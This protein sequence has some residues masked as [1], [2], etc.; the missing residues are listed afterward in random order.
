MLKYLPLIAW[1]PGSDALYIGFYDPLLVALSIG[2]A[3]FASYAGLLVSHQVTS[4]SLTRTRNIWVVV[5]GLCLGIGIWAMHFIGMLAFSLPCASSYD[6]TGTFLSTIPAVLAS[7]LAISIIGKKDLGFSRLAVGGLLIGS[8]IGVMHYAGMAAMRLEGQIRYNTWLFLLSLLVAVVLAIAALWINFR[9]QAL[10]ARWRKWS[11]WISACVMGTAVSGMHYTAMAATYFVR[12]VGETPVAAGVT[13]TILASIVLIATCSIVVVTIVAT[14]LDR[15]RWSS[16]GMPYRLVGALLLVWT[17]IAW[18]SS[19]YYYDQRGTDLYLKELQLADQQARDTAES[20]DERLEMLKAI[21]RLGASNDDIAQALRNS[22]VPPGS[23]PPLEHLNQYLQRMRQNLAVDEIYVLDAKG[24][25]IAASNAASP[26]S[27]VG[28]NFGDRDYFLLSRAGRQGRQYAMGR[29]SKVAGLYYATP[30]LQSGEFL[31]AVVVKRDVEQLRYL[32]NKSHAFVADTNGVVI[33]ASDKHLEFLALD[34]R[35]SDRLTSTQRQ[36]RY[37][38]SNFEPLLFAPAGSAQFP[39]ALRLADTPS[40]VVQGT[41]ELPEDAVAVHVIRPLQ[42]LVRYQAERG[43]LFALIAVSGNMF[44]LAAVGIVFYL[45]ELRRTDDNLRIAATAF[46]SQQGMMVTNAEHIILRVNKAF[47]QITGF[48]AAEVLGKTPHMLQSG[49]HDRTFYAGMDATLHGV[50]VWQGEVWNRRKNGDIFPE[51]LT[52]SAVKDIAGQVTH[53]VAAFLDITHHKSAQDQI[54]NLAFY[55]PLTSLPNRRLMMDRLDKAL[56][57][58]SRHQ[59]NSAL[60]YVDLDNF[61]TLNDT[62]GHTLG[63]L[64]L[65]QVAQ[66]LSACVRESDTIAR[67]G[68]DEFVVM[69]EDLSA[70]VREAAV[71]AESVSE[72]ILLSL[73]SDYRLEFHDYRSS[74]SIGITLFGGSDDEKLEE[75]LKRAELAM[76]QAKTAGRNTM[77]FFDPQMQAE[78]MHRAE[79]ESDLRMAVQDS[80]LLLYF[81]AQVIGDGRVTGVEAL[82]RWQHPVR[83]L[84]SPAEFIP[85]AE[86]TGLILPIGQWVL[87]EACSVLADWAGHADLGHLTIAVN[88]SARQFRHKDFVSQ[89]LEVLD[90]TGANPKCLKLELTES[91][92]VEDVEDVIAKMTALKARGV[93][94]SLDDFGTGYSSLSY[95]KRLP[96]DQLKIDQ[97]F[98]RNV[99]TEP[100]DAAIA[101]MVIALAGSLGLT[102]IAEGV[103]LEAQRDFLARQGC[104]AYQGYLFSRPLPLADFLVYLRR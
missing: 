48:S 22:K 84:V 76:F 65:K 60:L 34:T 69:L 47:T 16:L 83:G 87:S 11:T 72:K 70:N 101:K 12:E 88:V 14:S 43:W 54:N 81:Q 73:A 3:I 29:V 71:Q 7:A 30:V 78:V 56:G 10:D 63:D 21:S 18:L 17:T 37:G 4:A 25:C 44:V 13:P 2:I 90:A 24:T 59:R 68:S 92:L 23:R 58:V 64:L 15:S 35:V 66:R 28:Q 41:K 94:F 98:I 39:A 89:V 96:L 26:G 9:L 32:V 102:V 49:R 45:R 36:M 75:P 74:S 95:L 46:E 40:L 53:Y 20:L 67:V 31:G 85:L 103:E 27:F 6:P 80:Q 8:A 86:D 51:W 42:D 61:K 100:N 79:L 33:L 104:H 38:R 19:G 5:G 82:V 1:V 97:G 93:G 50:G 55:D 57:T 99:L 62:L 52:I 77:R 91:L